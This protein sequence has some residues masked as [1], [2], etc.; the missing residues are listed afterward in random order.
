MA[1]NSRTT[2][3]RVRWLVWLF[4]GWTDWVAIG[5]APQPDCVASKRPPFEH[6]G[7][8]LHLVAIT[9]SSGRALVSRALR[10]PTLASH[11]TKFLD[12]G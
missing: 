12:S 3:D 9:N 1:S 4:Q 11:A 8:A 5:V 10:Q 7:G 2:R 6:C